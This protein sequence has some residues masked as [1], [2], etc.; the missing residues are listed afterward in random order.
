MDFERIATR[1]LF[2]DMPVE[3]A[4]N[5]IRKCDSE[6]FI[7]DF[8]TVAKWIDESFTS[9]EIEL[10]GRG[11]DESWISINNEKLHNEPTYKRCLTLFSRI[12]GMLLKLDQ[13]NAP[14]VDFCNLLRWRSITRYLGE[15][16]LTTAYTASHDFTRNNDRNDFGWNDVLHHNYGDLN[17]ELSKGL[18]DVHAHYR[19][20]A[21]IF[22]LNWISMMNTI[23]VD[24]EYNRMQQ[25]QSV[26]FDLS[27]HYDMRTLSIAACFLRL[28]LYKIIL[29]N[30]PIDKTKIY[31][32][33]R[34]FDD[35]KYRN[36]QISDIRVGVSTLH[37]YCFK[38]INGNIIDY[39][40]NNYSNSNNDVNILHFGE[41]KLFYT[42][43]RKLLEG[44]G[45]IWEI[46][47]FLYLYILIKNK[48]R[49]EFEQTNHL[50]GFKNFKYYQDRKSKVTVKHNILEK[51]Y[52]K[53]VVQTC[54]E[55]SNDKVEL[56]TMNEVDFR[57]FEHANCS[58]GSGEEVISNLEERI[59]FVVSFGKEEYD[60]Q[61]SQNKTVRY[62][63]L[64]R[65]IKNKYLELFNKCSKVLPFRVGGI[66]AAG[67]ELQCRPEV[68]S[69]VYRY[70]QY[71]GLH[72]LTYHV[73]EDFY[74]LIDGLRAI[75]EAMRFLELGNRSRLGHALA[76]G[77]DADTYYS[78]RR[79]NAVL[80]RQNLL[81]NLV[82]LHH[83]I[84]SE[85]I[86]V[87]ESLL[88]YMEEK[89][90][91]LAFEIGYKNYNIVSYWNSW[92][93]RGDDYFDS[94]TTLPLD[95]WSI[96]SESH[97]V[98]AQNARKDD[99]AIKIYHNYL[100]DMKIKQ[101]GNVIVEEKL[102]TT[103]VSAIPKIQ[104]SL[105]RKVVEKGIAIE[106][107]PSSNLHIG[108]FEKY[109]DIPLFK[110]N[111][112]E[113]DGHTTMV[114]VS[115]NTDDRGVF[116]TSIYNEYSL[117]AAA[118]FKMKDQEGNRRYNDQT[119]IKYIGKIRENGFKQRF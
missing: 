82:W 53:F 31:D 35:I 100:V 106:C 6:G 40:I 115:V 47:G 9:S 21:S 93:L 90:M 11:M 84:R 26:F 44:N 99:V 46:A 117:I 74:D 72:R 101:N 118:L 52:S 75:D 28:E 105:I 18:S 42:A 92:L 107:N 50:N 27:E 5:R 22:A 56:R 87:P 12:S 60:K 4:V 96:T 108:P 66:D 76:L 65:I 88:Q 37:E 70:A 91:S 78:K 19:A 104:E 69:H 67:N 77:V 109:I 113:S 61:L 30:Y 1:A 48:I 97:D 20:S 33:W 15:D 116:A 25:P 51:N 13:G 94:D 14:V 58:I 23:V 24:N 45:K 71:M 17:E 80:P 34:I 10:L 114:N 32:I 39:A 111:P 49:R 57:L 62:Y 55:N 16:V 95:G 2:Y 83:V 102:P 85:D 3:K 98:S 112:I 29:L 63:S 68:F 73:G 36:D 38:T 59:S 103:L 89:A 81:D 54:L 119:I 64:R 79:M 7:E 43:F 86:N 8:C 41:R 110:F